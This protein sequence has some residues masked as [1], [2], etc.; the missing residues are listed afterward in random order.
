M[1]IAS[2]PVTAAGD[3]AP[4]QAP[5]R[6]AARSARPPGVTP[7]AGFWLVA[8]AFAVLMAF[9]TAPTPLWPLYAAR[10]G[11]GPTTVTEVFAVLVGGAAFGFLAFGHLS[12]RFGRRRVVVA[13]LGVGAAAALLLA[14]WTDL[15]GLVVGRLL[16]GL[17]IGLMASTATTYL[18]DLY[19]REHPDRPGSTVPGVVSTA[20]NLGGLALGPLVA[21]AIA[22]WVPHPLTVTQLGFAVAMTIALLLTL[23]TPET[24]DRLAAAAARPGRFAL[25]PGGRGVFASAAA[26][27]FFSFALFGLVSS[28]GAIM[29][30]TRLGISSAFDAGLAPFLMFVAAAVGQLTLARLSRV[31]A[32]GRRRDG[33]PARARAGR[34]LALPPGAVALPGRRRAGRRGR[35]RAVQGGRRR[36]RRGRPPGLPGRRAGGLLRRRLR[37][38][39]GAVDPVQHRDPASEHRGLDDRVRGRALRGRRGL[40]GGGGPPH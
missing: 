5:A 20:A 33:L 16:N 32:A 26:L 27:G 40:D 1:P 12:D 36:G 17:A 38:H 23:I 39:G 22:Q 3:P 11:F 35:G 37:G 2:R 30:H 7:G 25:R 29:L 4:P 9:G 13:A 10:D 24:V 21:G 34:R 18:H 15:P 31:A 28:L 19:A 6:R 8:A 14:L